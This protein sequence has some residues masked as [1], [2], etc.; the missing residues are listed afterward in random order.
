[1]FSLKSMGGYISRLMQLTHLAPWPGE[2]TFGAISH[3][4]SF[5]S[6]FIRNLVKDKK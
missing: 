5:I 3:A 2:D 4:V 6:F 1:M